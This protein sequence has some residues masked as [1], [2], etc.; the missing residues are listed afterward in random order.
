[1]VRTYLPPK[2]D[3]KEEMRKQ[4][5]KEEMEDMEYFGLSGESTGQI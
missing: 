5:L 2:V 4:K 3:K 1:M